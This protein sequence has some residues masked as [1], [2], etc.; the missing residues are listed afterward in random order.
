[1]FALTRSIAGT[2]RSTARLANRLLVLVVLAA[3]AGM[4]SAAADREKQT[5][6]VGVLAYTGK[7]AAVVRWQSTVDYLSEQNRDYRFVIEPLYLSELRNAFVEGSLDFVLTQ[8]LQYAELTRL[9]QIWPLATMV[10]RDE[11]GN[12]LERLGAVVFTREGS[13]FETIDDLVGTRVAGVSPNALGGWLLGMEALDQVGIDVAREITPIFTGLPLEEVIEAVRNGRAH[14]GVVRASFFQR[15]LEQY[16]DARLRPVGPADRSDF[17]YPTNTPL[18]PEWPF[19]ATERAPEAVVSR[20]ADQLIGMPTDARAARDGRITGWRTPLDYTGM[21]RLRDKWLPEPLTPAALISHYGPYLVGLIAMVLGLFAL[22]A[23][24]GTRRVRTEKQRLRRAFSGL[25]TGAILTDRQG[26][27][28]LANR[29]VQPFARIECESDLIDRPVCDVFALHLDDLP[30]RCD[31]D[32]LVDRIEQSETGSIDGAIERGQQRFD[33]NLKLSR[34]QADGETQFIVSMLDVTDLRSAHALLTYRATHDRLT[35]LLKLDAMEEFLTQAMPTESA[36]GGSSA[37]GCV[38]WADLDDFRLLNEIGTRELGDRILASLASHFSLELP[39]DAVIARM[40][41]DEF[42]IWMPMS[43]RDK[44]TPI[45][46]DVLEIVHS[47]RLPDEH[48]HLRLKASIGVTRMDSDNLPAARWLEDAERAS[49]SAHRL[50]GDRVVQFSG[51][52]TEL[53]E[54]EQ[55]IA[56]YS[57]LRSAIAEDRLSLVS[58]R[59]EPMRPDAPLIHEI[60]LRVAAE[61]G[62]LRFPKEFI[63]IAEK[64]QAMQDI[65]RWVI[66]HA[67]DWLGRQQSADW[68]ISINL[69]GHSVQDPAMLEYI[70]QRLRETHLDPGRIIFEITE[71]AAI[72]N[73]DQA[74]RLIHSIRDLGCRFALDDFGGGFLSFEFLR[75]LRPDIVKVDGQ[76]IADLPD[77]PV[78]AVIVDAIIQVCRVMDAETVVEWVETE[79]QHREVREMGADYVQG[80][81]LHRPEPLD[82]LRS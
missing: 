35:G 11:A 31:F 65:D 60:L 25:H 18:V 28:L 3:F 36:A 70:R 22:Q 80:F 40:G 43:N 55:Q 32:Q 21:E 68:S 17:P 67:S 81:L 75:R 6:T 45:A 42:A 13:G 30:D 82:A 23:R 78:A 73:L 41:V 58:Q 2:S 39:S 8:S 61:D 52:D 54:R 63:E 33:V 77:D 59:I 15:Y 1:M 72:L 48:N 47:F 38:I 53:M 66:R 34:L 71:T 20:V 29:A 44:C 76:L 10:V 57:A 64:H 50:G 4:V 51:G 74:E 26:R 14:A 19:A 16:P 5:L 7:D 56:R 49:Q 46:N 24:R 79:A 27:I 12:S 9:G 62:K 37:G 69:S